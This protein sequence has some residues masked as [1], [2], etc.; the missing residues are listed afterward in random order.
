MGL[1]R[2]ACFETRRFAPLLS[3][4]KAEDSKNDRHAEEP[5]PRGVSKHAGRHKPFRQSLALILSS[6][7]LATAAQAAPLTAQSLD[8]G[9]SFRLDPA[10]PA[11]KAHVAD[12]AWRA[13][14]T[15]GTVQT[16]LLANHAIPDPYVGQNE[17][18]LQ[19]IGLAG[20]QYRK[21]LTVD[22]AILQRDHV[23]LVFDGLDTFASVF[24]NGQKLIAADNM[25]RAWRL[26]VKGVLHA[27]ANTIEVDFASPI[28]KLQPWLLKQPYVLPGAYDSMF[29]DEPAGVQTSTYL[30]KAP[31]NY[32]WDWGPRY[33]TEGIWRPVRLEAWDNVRLADFHVSQ[34]K[35]G[36]DAAALT[37]QF[38]VKVDH[39]E[40]L[41]LKIEATG[42]DGEAL[43]PVSQTVEAT[44]GDNQLRV[45]ISIAK[46]KLWWPVGYGAPNL[47]RVSATVT[48]ASGE[49]AKTD[50]RI[51]LRTVELRR[52]SDAWGKSF[53]FVVNGVPIFAKGANLI[54]FDSFPPRA[55]DAQM[56]RELTSAKAANMNMLRIWGGGYYGTD[57]FYDM[58]DEMGLMIWQEFMFGGAV[59]PYDVAF[60]ENTRQEAIEQV[61]RLRDHPSIVLWC[62]NNEVQTGWENWGDRI[63]FKDTLAPAERERIV[64]GM[65]TIFGQVLRGAVAQYSPQTPYIAGSPSTDLDGPADQDKDGD[66]HYWAVWGGSPVEAY[67][68][69]TPRFQSEYGLQSFPEM[70]TIMSVA[71]PGDLSVNSP[72]IRAHQKYDKGNGNDRLLLYIRRNYGEPKDFASFVYL[73]QVMQADGIELAATHLRSSRPQTMGSLYWQL[74]DVWPGAS[75]SSIDYFGRWKALQFH[76]RRF[77]APVIVTAIRNKGATVASVVSDR[78]T[79]LQARWRLRVMDVDGGVLETRTGELAVPSLA[80]AKIEALDDA[81]YLK[82]ADPARTFAVYDLYDGDKPISRAVVYFAAAK[83]MPLPDPGVVSEIAG[84]AGDYTLTL[85]ANRLA[86]AVWVGFGDTDVDVSDNAFDLLPGETVTLKLKSAADLATLKKALTVQTLYG[87]TTGGVS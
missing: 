31:Y 82:G 38:D 65:T 49:V 37:A 33:V 47:Y 59:P 66:R 71:A 53:E 10:D 16:D 74:N 52:E 75:W 17:A 39:P 36:A 50:K 56:R 40:R 83:A 11:A 76:A 2:C 5:L 42:P 8:Q 43:L 70:R 69:E 79:P 23:E 22:A 4:T 7:F 51:G 14:T 35:I 45:P 64:I 54:P 18:K 9:W 1:K 25:F 85:K 80:V 30:R 24:V 73:S 87:A 44:P 41:T 20:W 58:A 19:W 62:G 32:G 48:D 63:A 77:Y 68:G 15:P 78:T 55:T 6:L 84:A 61:I 28:A 26:P 81:A 13:A 86:R 57:S 72:V 34:D 46:P 27:G 29:G 60:R 21:T 67:L 12:T 3:M